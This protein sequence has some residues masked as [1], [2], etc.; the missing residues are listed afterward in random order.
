MATPAMM[1][2]ARYQVKGKPIGQGGMGVVYKAYDIVTKRDVALKTMR[3]TL[4][5]AALELFSKEWTVLARVSHPNIIDILDTGEFEEDGE[6]KPFFVMPLLPGATLEH[7]IANASTRLTVDRIVGIAAQTCRGLQ[8]AHEQGLIHRDLKPSNIFVMDDDTVKIIDFG[9]VHLAGADS[10]KGVKGT[11][12]YMAP[13]QIEMKPTSPASDIFSLGVVCYQALTGRKP[14]ARKT[15]AETI[16]AIRRHIPPPVCELNPLVSQIVSRVIHKA[17]AK[18]PWHRFSTA[19]EFSET[20]QKALNGQSIERF[21]R[22]KIQPRI[23]RAKKAQLEGDHQFASEI[24]TELEAEGN[25]DPEMTMLRIQLDQAIRQKSIRQLLDSARTRLEEDEFP[26][27]LQ[28]IQEVLGIDPDNADALGLRKQIEQQR[29]ERQ[30]QNWFRLVEQHLHNH[31]FGQAKQALEEILKLNAKDSRAREMLMEVDRREQEINQLRAEKEQLYQSAVNC[32]QHGEVSSALSKLERVLELHRQSPDSAIPDRDAQ[33]QSLYNQIRTERE[34]ARSSYAEGR[35]HLADRNFARALELCAEFLKKSP[36]DPMFQALKLEAEEQQRQE[37]SSF[38]ADVSRRVEAEADLDRRVNILKEAAER[39]PDEPH[40]Q[41]SLRLV[42]ERRD[43]VNSIVGKARQYEERGQFNEALS[44]FDILRNIYAQYSGIEFEAERLKRRRDEQVREEA[45]AR[46]VDQID[47][48][49]AAGDYARARELVRTAISEFPNDGELSGLE[50]LAQQALERAAEAAEWLQRGQKLCFD[51]QFGEGLEALRKAA[52]LDNRNAVIRAALLNALVEQARSVLGKDWRAAEPLIEQALNIDG[53]HPL[54]KS[55]QGLVLDYKRQEILN[56]CVS[57]ARE[58]QANGDLSGALAKVE[59][60]LASHPNELRLV[61]L[62]STLRN[63]GAVSPATPTPAR[64]TDAPPTPVK[65]E[66]PPAAQMETVSLRHDRPT[67]AD[68]AFT[69]DRSMVD[70]PA[71]PKTASV[72]KQPEPAVRKPN[73]FWAGARNML[74]SAGSAF[75]RLPKVLQDWAEPKGRFSKLQWGLIAAAPVLLILALIASRRPPPPPTPVSTDYYV[76]LESNVA[77]TKYRVDGNPAASPPLRLPSGSHTVEAFL[78]GYK[79]ATKSFTLSPGVAR[80]YP[81]SFRLEPELVQLRLSSDLKS[82]KVKLDGQPPVDLQDGSFV[83]DGIALSE[84]HTFS[85]MQAGKESLVFSFRGEPGGMVTLSTPVKA[86]DLNAVVIASLAARARV[87]A[88]DSS[89]KGGLNDQTPQLIADGGVEFG[90]ITANTELR[91]DD[92]KSTRVRFLEVGNA[93]TL[94]VWLA[95][96]PNQ[97]TLQVE[98]RVPGAEASVDGSKPRTLRLGKENY[99]GLVPG[100][101]NIRV[102]R[103]GYEAVDRKV[104]VTKGK[105][106]PLLMDEWK[107][108]VRTASLTIDGAT[109]EAEVSIDGNFRGNVGIDGTFR[110]GELSPGEHTITL[111][112]TNFEDKQLQR[113]FTVGQTVRLS[114]ADGQLTPFGAL[115]FRVSP[116]SASITYKRPEEAQSHAAENGKAVPVRAGRYVVTATANGYRPHPAETVTVES[117]KSLPIDWTL[118]AL[119]KAPPPPPP[120]PKL[121][122]T[123]DYFQEP[124]GWTQNGAWW[125][126]KGPAVSWLRRNQ[127]VYT[128]EFLR[129][130]SKIGFVKRTK[131]VEWIIDQGS[132]NRIEYSFDFGTLERK[133]TVDGKTESTK[134]KLPPTAGSGDSYAIEIEIGPDQ[135]VIKD[136]QGKELDRYQRPNRSEPLGKFGFKGDVALAIKRAEER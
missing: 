127:G 75:G 61:Q 26:L 63:L 78:P 109:R 110:L 16:D 115:D 116:Q 55:L 18:D 85:L 70:V 92:G 93:P 74:A 86:K 88:S 15:E 57:R 113:A 124:A 9:V 129:Q 54:A 2:N 107:P 13:E 77:N 81:V 23:D 117:G 58:L 89:L 1:I 36:G 50:R 38:I 45:K 111:R 100:A 53:G 44:Q 73:A 87:Y 20:I 31:S 118:A 102:T 65:S 72:P 11:L 108:V 69:V 10:I 43:L 79:P 47:R 40:F 76:D 46:W 106:L 97:G 104:E 90:V 29:S 103:D 41:Q 128:I 71:A 4:N 21:D 126:H 130:T 66:E 121:T 91:I 133:A 27:A 120:P 3:G 114:G 95:S 135:I 35:R 51:R 7:L 24:L 134:V 34:A 39:Y 49:I 25:I 84:E 42:R 99:F 32:Y 19:R 119:E 12:Q 48:H 101:H 68:N 96:D 17:M 14:F 28:K 64:Q 83:N 80:P 136:A 123:K 112:K 52:S 37:Q 131:H 82:G 98:V 56:D 94:T 132:F 6:R 8:A 30:T 62:R 122:L 60:V 59:E 67:V 105:M 5:P 33:Y 22:E 125:I